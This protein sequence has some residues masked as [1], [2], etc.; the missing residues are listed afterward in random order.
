MPGR[1]VTCAVIPVA[2][3]VTT[4]G[5]EIVGAV[6]AAGLTVTAAVAVGLVAPAPFRST[7]VKA[8]VPM[9]PAV[10]VMVLVVPTVTPAEPP[11][12]VMVPPEMVHAYVMPA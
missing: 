9:G 2:P 1:A 8:R 10:Y 12:L 4:A 11:A 7:Q 6:G 3:A 5:A